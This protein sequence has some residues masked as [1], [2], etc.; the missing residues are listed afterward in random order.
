M[1]PILIVE[2]KKSMAE[3]LKASLKAEGYSCVLASKASEAV[4]LLKQRAFDLVLS[5]LKLPDKNGLDV[6]KAVKEEDPSIP[7]IIMTAY[8]SIETAVQAIKEGAFDFITKPFDMDHLLVL[9]KRALEQNRLYR[10][11][12]L[13]RQ[14]SSTPEGM[15]TIVGKSRVI[16]ELL[17][18]VKKVAK[19]R[20]TVLLLGES[21]TGKELFARAIHYLSPR[22][23]GMFVPVNCA[24][25]P[26]DLLESELFG[27]EKGAFTG[28]TSRRLGK[29]ELANGGTIFLD[30]VAELEL[31]LQA[32]LLRVLQDHTIE[33]VGG[34]KQI[35]VDVRVIAASNIDLSRAVK[36]GRFREDLFYRL[37][38]F[39][40]EI[41]PLRERK[42]DIPLLVDFFVEKFSKEMKIEKKRVTSEALQLLMDYNWKGN[43][44]ELENTIERAMIL[45]DGPTIEPKHISLI[46]PD[47]EACIESL[48]MDGPLEE[49]TKAA[50]RLAE[51]VRIKKALQQTRWNKT[52]AAELLQIS[53]KTLLNKIKEYNLE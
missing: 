27:H 13:L 49:T 50:L 39:P 18:R 6:L 31:S 24:A 28:A 48:P 10:E 19:T 26:R 2:D 21:G 14:E 36:E 43:V 41:P 16:R 7:V 46:T 5:D 11:N 17:E 25:I 45:S 23:D 40:V 20:S 22:R 9:I 8:G 1:N 47:T 42:E 52:R 4:N 3:M 34:S 53:Y 37:N 51:S 30:E 12:I 32:K 29:F 33:R 15:P 35:K 38:V 44:R